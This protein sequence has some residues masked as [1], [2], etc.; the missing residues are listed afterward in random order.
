MEPQ[1]QDETTPSTKDRTQAAARSHETFQT[2]T[3]P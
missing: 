2:A 3:P 1:P